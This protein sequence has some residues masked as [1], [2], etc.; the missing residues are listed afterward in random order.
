MSRT[1]RPRSSIPV[2]PRRLAVLAL[3]ASIAVVAATACG[4]SGGSAAGSK[5]LV[6]GVPRNFGYLSTMWARDVQPAGLHIDYKYFPN[7]TDMLAALNSGRIDLTEIGDVGALQSYENGGGNAK[8][9]AV[10]RPNADSLGL[11][12][13]KTSKATSLADLKGKKIQ[14]LKSTNSYTFFRNQVKQARLRESDFHVVQ[15]S[16]P[17]AN[18]AFQSG[19][20]DG[21]YTIDPNLADLQHQ[22]GARLIATARQFAV[23]NIYPYVATVSA[24]K[25]KPAAIAAFVKALAANFAWIKDNPE[26]QA[27]LLAPKIGF[28]QAAIRASFARAGQALQPIDATF[29][30][31]EQRVADELVATKIL[32]RPVRVSQVFI[33]DFNNDAMTN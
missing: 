25:H 8:V 7:F 31:S 1:T 9:V 18:K 2:A 5:T 13:P 21:Y 26:Q 33:P 14:F 22:T 19:Q 15:I 12:V 24:I 11:L 10:T 27:A 32:P 28:S 3:L 16:G 17:A 29:L 6:V 20:V 30:A 23:S 4:S